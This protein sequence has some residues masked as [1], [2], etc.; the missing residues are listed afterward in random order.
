MV[1][2]P[3]PHGKRTTFSGHR[4]PVLWSSVCSHVT[5]EYQV[6]V[7]LSRSAVLIPRSCSHFDTCW[8]CGLHQQLDEFVRPWYPDLT[9][10][11]QGDKPQAHPIR[12][13]DLDLVHRI[14]CQRRRGIFQWIPQNLQPEI[15]KRPRELMCE[16]AQSCTQPWSSVT[17]RGSLMYCFLGLLLSRKRRSDVFVFFTCHPSQCVRPPEM[18]CRP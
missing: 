14:H 6:D 13:H 8:L 2:I 16:I 9:N 1:N 5:A 12:V 11:F 10:T 17:N 18:L 7:S 4:L 15:A 3:E